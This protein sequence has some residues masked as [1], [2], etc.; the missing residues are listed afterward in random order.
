MELPH[1]ASLS[2]IFPAWMTWMVGHNV[3]KIAQ[4]TVRVWGVPESEDKKAVALE[5][6]KAEKLSLALLVCL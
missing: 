3:G 6:G 2:V 5:G 4:Y 1:G